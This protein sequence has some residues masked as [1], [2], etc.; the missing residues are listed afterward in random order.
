MMRNIHR[1]Q[2]RALE[3]GVMLRPHLK[4]VKSVDAARRI[5]LNG[6]GPATVSTLAE[7][8]VFAGAG[9][10]DIV[11]AV[12]ITPQ[13][14]ERV[15]ALVKGGC[16]LCVLL[17][18]RA[19]AQAVSAASE[20]AQLRIPA[21]I[22]IDSDAHRSGLRFDDPELI[23]IGKILDSGPAQLRGVLCHAGESYGAVGEQA[24]SE[25]AE[26]E[27]RATVNAAEQLRKAGLPCPVVSVGSTPTAFAARKL[28][29]VTELRAGV[30]VFFDLVMAGIGVCTLDDIALSVLTTVI[31]HQADKGWVLIDAGWMAMSQ[32]RGTRDQQIDQGYG[33]VCDIHGNVLEDLIV[34]RANQE[35]GVRFAA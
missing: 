4:T 18:S 32:D 33:V 3:L 21:L 19:Q 7:A 13:K 1:L 5:L 17:D 24:Q 31:G 23:S 6:S 35:H 28:D 15:L 27:R 22:E 8:E 12:G 9:I 11:Y 30:H 16:D 25:F 34:L 29:G 2:G 26:Q 20:Q 10:H 14:L